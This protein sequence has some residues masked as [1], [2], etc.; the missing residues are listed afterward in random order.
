M[1]DLSGAP[2]GTCRIWGWSQS[3]L[4]DPVVGD[5]L[6]SLMNDDCESIS[7]DFITV[8]R[9]EPV[10][11]AGTISTTDNT[12]ICVDGNPDPINVTVMGSPSGGVGGW[13]ITDDN[14]N[15]LA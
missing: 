1:L 13:I 7:V 3:G 2:P 5:P 12:T 8:I 4:S 10:I 9:N 6:S 11:N 15:I 14:N